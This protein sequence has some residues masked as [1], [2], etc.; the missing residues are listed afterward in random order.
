MASKATIT[1]RAKQIQGLFEEGAHGVQNS[2]V[3]V[4]G[5]RE[6]GLMSIDVVHTCAAHVKLFNDLLA[7]VTNLDCDNHNKITASH[8]L[9][10]QSATDSEP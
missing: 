1:K 3:H 7:H 5:F 2:C 6:F 8:L 9:C 4:Q 10:L